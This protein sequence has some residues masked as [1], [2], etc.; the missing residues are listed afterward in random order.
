M[1]GIQS[2]RAL[3]PCRGLCRCDGCGAVQQWLAAQSASDVA[4]FS[5]GRLGGFGVLYVGEIPGVVEQ[6]V[7]E[8]VGRAVFAQAADRGREGR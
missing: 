1:H 3:G 8:V 7:G 4:G 6:A 5:D 2:R